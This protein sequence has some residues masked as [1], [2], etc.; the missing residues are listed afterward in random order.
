MFNLN[1]VDPDEQL[2]EQTDQ[3]IID[4]LVEEFYD[5][6][7]NTDSRQPNVQRIHEF[8]I[9][10][11]ILVNNSGETP[12]VYDLDSFIR[13]RAE[14]LTNGTLTDFKE[15]ESS[16]TLEIYGN[17]AH[18]TSGYIKRGTLNGEPYSGE[19][20]KLMQFVKVN[21]LWLFASVT[22]TDKK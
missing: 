8:F 5:L 2:P 14:I 19:G 3:Q 17:I 20:T 11:G 21:D 7:T 4:Q 18:R 22:W 13:P 15:K 6:F 12:E 9:E 16:A 1:L 10:N